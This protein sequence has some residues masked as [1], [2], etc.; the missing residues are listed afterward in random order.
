M[1]FK[2]GDL[3]KTKG[4]SP[5]YG[6]VTQV[7]DQ[8]ITYRTA[9]RQ[10][11]TATADQLEVGTGVSAYL[12]QEAP[13]LIELLANSVTF[14]VGN[15]VMG[16]QFMNKENVKF[17]VQNALYEFLLKGWVK[18]WMIIPVDPL[19]GDAMNALVSQQDFMDGL[20]K[21]VA[22]EVID[23]IYRLLMKQ[24]L[25][26]DSLWYFLKSATAISVANVGQRYFETKGSSYMPQ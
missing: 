1:T 7:D 5:E 17:L 13:D 9:W 10:T 3:V 22:I 2:I 14:A 11:K 24:K 16:K 8:N 25:G 18:D 4:D 26:A 6:T 19:R 12:A 15:R 21:A 23:V 20:N